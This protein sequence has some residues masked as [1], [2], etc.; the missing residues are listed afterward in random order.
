MLVPDGLR[1][2]PILSRAPLDRR[3]TRLPG[4]LMA[5]AMAV[6]PT[7]AG[8]AGGSE[9]DVITVNDVGVDA[10]GQMLSGGVLVRD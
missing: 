4:L 3:R 10:T 7:N 6:E 5:S 2:R 9:G 8:E 1:A